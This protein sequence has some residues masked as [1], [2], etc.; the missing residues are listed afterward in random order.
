MLADWTN[1]CDFWTKRCQ[2]WN[3]SL[4][5]CFHLYGPNDWHQIFRKDL[6]FKFIVTSGSSTETAVP[7][8]KLWQQ[9]DSRICRSGIGVCQKGWKLFFFFNFKQKSDYV[10]TLP[11]ESRADRAWSWGPENQLLCNTERISKKAARTLLLFFPSQ[12]LPVCLAP[13]WCFMKVCWRDE[14]VWAGCPYSL[15]QSPCSLFKVNKHCKEHS[16]LDSTHTFQRQ[17]VWEVH[18][19]HTLPPLSR[20]HSPRAGKTNLLSFSPLSEEGGQL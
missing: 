7:S 13:H 11:Y 10:L 1:L 17:R 6:G 14:W 20:L 16:E 19:P 4:H 3:K 5:L 8:K 12:C 2:L 18:A 15:A 9:N